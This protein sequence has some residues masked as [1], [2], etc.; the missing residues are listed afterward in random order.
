MPINERLAK[1]K[2]KHSFLDYAIQ[3]EEN[4][5]LPDTLF[6]RDLKVRKLRLKEEMLRLNG[7]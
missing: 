4:K 6:V 7:K 3:R 2:M 5:S 1:L